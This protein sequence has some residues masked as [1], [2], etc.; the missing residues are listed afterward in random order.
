MIDSHAE[1]PEI[2]AAVRAQHG[3]QFGYRHTVKGI[4]PFGEHSMVEVYSN[5]AEDDRRT[6]HVL[7]GKVLNPW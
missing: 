2:T 7:N 4:G 6:V 5:Q 3:E 1:R